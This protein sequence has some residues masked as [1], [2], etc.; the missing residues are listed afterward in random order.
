M[1]RLGYWMY[2]FNLTHPVG[3]SWPLMPNY[4]KVTGERRSNRSDACQA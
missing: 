1:V 4:S 3:S 2:C